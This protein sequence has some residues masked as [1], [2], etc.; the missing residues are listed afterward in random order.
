MHMKVGMES[1]FFNG[2]YFLNCCVRYLPWCSVISLLM[3]VLYIIKHKFSI[4]QFIVPYFV[5]ALLVWMLVVPGS[6]FWYSDI[7]KNNPIPLPDSQ[8]LSAGY[9]RPEGEYLVY[10]AEALDSSGD[11]W[12]RKI[13]PD[14]KESNIAYMFSD[15]LIEQSINPPFWGVFMH[16]KCLM[17]KTVC[18][19]ALSQGYFSYILFASMG[20]ALFSV[21][22]LCRLSSWRLVNG[23]VVL[24]MFSLIILCNIQ[25]YDS[26]VI[27]R[28]PFIGNWWIPLAFNGTICVLF[29]TI[30]IINWVRHPDNEGR[31][32]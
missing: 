15:P 32:R 28:I 27:A 23:L 3:L 29:A 20:F 9:F 16:E 11:I 4:P 21:I 17:L 22:F 12:R 5:L 10:R 8:S 7:Q 31:R 2:R 1:P 26:E 14:R 19:N 25:F 18:R 30:G 13:F 6:S 24:I